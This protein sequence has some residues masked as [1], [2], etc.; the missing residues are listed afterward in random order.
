MRE[1]HLHQELTR[2]ANRKQLS[3]EGHHDVVS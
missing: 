1:I 2:R 3:G